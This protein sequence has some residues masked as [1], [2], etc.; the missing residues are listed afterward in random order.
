VEPPPPPPPVEPPPPPPPVQPPPVE[1]PYVPPYI[2]PEE[3]PP[4]PGGYGPIPPPNVNPIFLEPLAYPGVNPGFVLGAVRPAY[5]AT[6]PYQQRYYWGAQPYFRYMED[7]ANYNVIPGGLPPRPEQ[8][9]PWWA[10]PVAYQLPTYGPN[11]E[12]IP[13]TRGAPR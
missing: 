11:M 2:P 4:G 5:E 1:P 13:P 12:I 3:P 7:L 6:A 10:Q 8:P 9:M